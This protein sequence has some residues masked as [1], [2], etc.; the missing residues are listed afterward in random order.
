MLFLSQLL[1]Q[2]PED[3]HNGKGGGCNWIGEI[4]TWGTNSTHNGNWTVSIRGTQTSNLSSSL[5]E[6]SQF[7]SKICWIT[8]ITRHFCQSTWNFS[9]GF[10]P[11]G[12]WVS[13]HGNISTHISEIFSQSDSCVDGGLSG[14]HRH[15]GCV[16]HQRCSLH[17]T[18]FLSVLHGCEEGEFLQDF[19]HFISSFSATH[20]NNNLTI[21]MLGECLRDACFSTPKGSWNSTC[22]TQNWREHRI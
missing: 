22:S 17:D 12:C 8:W 14:S 6:L 1:I 9:Q 13:H 7:G 4:T 19:S 20:I 16:S 3:L 5:V 2:A 15:V 11:S 10:C 18:D 21:R